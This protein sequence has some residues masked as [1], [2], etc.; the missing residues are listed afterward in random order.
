MFEIYSKCIQLIEKIEAYTV[1]AHTYL[2]FTYNKSCHHF[3]RQNYCCNLPLVKEYLKFEKNWKV[4]DVYQLQFFLLHLLP[5]CLRLLK[6][7]NLSSR[8]TTQ[9]CEGLIQKMRKFSH[10][11]SKK[12]LWLKHVQERAQEK[13][14]QTS[15]N[16]NSYSQ[17]HKQNLQMF[18]TDNVASLHTTMYTSKSK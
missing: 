17:V 7:D 13:I 8:Q 3:I 14:V 4:I 6:G 16:Y 11:F 1:K 5:T 18:I 12:N 9:P 10:I 15:T 2:F